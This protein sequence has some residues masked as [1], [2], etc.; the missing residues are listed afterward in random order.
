MYSHHLVLY[1]SGVPKLSMAM[2]PFSILT[3]QH[4]HLKFFMTKRLRK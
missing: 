3:E 1:R 2:Y 4:E